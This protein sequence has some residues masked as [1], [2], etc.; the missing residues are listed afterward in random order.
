[1]STLPSITDDT[2]ATEVLASETPVLV[3]FWA[4][5]CP[6]CRQVEPVLEGLA[7]EYGAK[8]KI[9]KM[10]S[11]ENVVTASALRV[12][13]LPTLKVFQGGEEVW[14][15]VGARSKRSLSADLTRFVD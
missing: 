15:I 1:M 4:E 5:W 13:S 12:M 9:V 11:D 8:L 7:A 2:F 3:D 10:N 6:P 14:S